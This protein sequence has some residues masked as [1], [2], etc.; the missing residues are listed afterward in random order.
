M[1]MKLYPGKIEANQHHAMNDVDDSIVEKV[2]HDL[3][4]QL[5]YEH[6]SQVVAEVTFEYQDARVKTFLP[7]LIHREALDRLRELLKARSS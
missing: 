5:P 4:E 7:I 1:S 3:H 6:V 2:W